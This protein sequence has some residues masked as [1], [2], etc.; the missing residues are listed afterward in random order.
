MSD[1]ETEVRG[2]NGDKWSPPYTS[3]TTLMNTVQRMADEGGVPSRIDRS[4]LSN[5]P[6]GVR[7]TFMASLK[8][9][10]LVD[11]KL[12]PKPS[13][14]GLVEATEKDRKALMR[15]IIQSIYS[16]PLALPRMATQS[17]LEAAFRNYGV[18]GSTLRKAIAFYLAA[19][20][21]T[22]IDHSPHF[23]LPKVEPGE[24]RQ[25]RKAAAGSG[26]TPPPPKPADPIEAELPGLDPFILG[27]VRALPSPGEAFPEGKQD[28]WFDTARGIFK[29]IYNTGAE[30]PKASASSGPT[31]GGQSD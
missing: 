10:G 30:S 16:E 22:G 21:F 13:M 2:S 27:L 3:F 14:I 12:A 23:K 5:M 24:R 8:S 7:S 20:R 28:A 31:G 11:D 4:Y 9:L 19:L 18:S 25:P 26:E 15:E 1:A 6:G 29:L 17:Q